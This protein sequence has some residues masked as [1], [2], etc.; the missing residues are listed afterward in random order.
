MEQQEWD[1]R[2]PGITGTDAGHEAQDEPRHHALDTRWGGRGAARALADGLVADQS[3]AI[4][5]EPG[6][7]RRRR[8]RSALHSCRAAP[9]VKATATMA[10]A[11]VSN[12][13]QLE[14]VAGLLQG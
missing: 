10:A 9:T 1:S 11:E 3:V 8:L 5:G 7:V 2:V 4:S 13:K 6:A 14:L 12:R